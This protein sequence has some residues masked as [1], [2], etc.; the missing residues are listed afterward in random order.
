MPDISEAIENNFQINDKLSKLFVIL[1][2]DNDDLVNDL[3][4][5]KT[6]KT[7]FDISDQSGTLFFTERKSADSI[8]SALKAEPKS[9]VVS[10][11]ESNKESPSTPPRPKP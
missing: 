1:P 4:V 8:K 7:V 10:L 2:K 9:P 6:E 5:D 3:V 11:D